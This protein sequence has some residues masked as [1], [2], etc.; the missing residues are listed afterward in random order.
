MSSTLIDP[1]QTSANSL[2]PHRWGTDALLVVMALIWGVNFI[3]VK[4]GA[5]LLQPLAFNSGRVTIAAVALV[6]IVLA[7][8]ERWPSRRD[9]VRLLA[10]GVLGNG[11]YQWFFIEGIARTRAGDAALVLAAAPALMAIIGRMLGVERVTRRKVLGIG[12]SLF[13][14]ALVVFGS[15]KTDPATTRDVATLAGN[16]LVLAA[17]F[18]WALYTVLLKPYTERVPGIPLSALT[19]VGG[20]IPLVAV[21]LPQ[22]AATPWTA[23]PISAWGALLYSGLLA[24]A[25]AY[26]FWYRGVRVLG[27]TRSAMYSNLQPVVALVVAWIALGEKPTVIQVL[28]AVAIMTGLLLTRT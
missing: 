21:S 8:R 26:L 12:A 17:C 1:P 28:G 3:V 23:L 11:L 24:L 6:L 16:M 25:V 10:L 9:T 5:Q 22:V 18:C 19:M 20:A 15:G 2:V 27:P 14:M 7:M 4:I 13:G